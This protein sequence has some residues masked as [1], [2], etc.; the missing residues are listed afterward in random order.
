MKVFVLLVLCA[1]ASCVLL[2][3]CG[4]APKYRPIECYEGQVLPEDIPELKELLERFGNEIGDDNEFAL[5]L[6]DMFDKKD[7]KEGKPSNEKEV[8]NL[9]GKCG[10][11]PKYLP[12]ECYEVNVLKRDRAQLK[13]AYDTLHDTDLKAFN[14]ILITLR[15]KR[16][17]YFGIDLE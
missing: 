5:Y 6:E 15:D 7:F 4:M 8:S 16:F 10:V 1:Y 9:L 12:F 3:K 13:E 2:G 14:E 17:A 11:A